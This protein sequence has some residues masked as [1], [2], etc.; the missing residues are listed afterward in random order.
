MFV[1][2]SVWTVVVTLVINREFELLSWL[3]LSKRIMFFR[4]THTFK[5]KA[6]TS[7]SYIA[8]GFSPISL[9]HSHNLRHSAF[10]FSLAKCDSPLTTFRR[11]AI[12]DWN[13]LPRYLKEITSLVSF[14]IALKRYLQNAWDSLSYLFSFLLI[15]V[16]LMCISIQK[17]FWFDRNGR[18]ACGREF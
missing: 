15:H 8:E 14:K 4:L 10:N 16:Y 7:P 11:K 5:I 18:T 3:P 2:R 9:T 6:G 17:V 1:L 13:L 12:S